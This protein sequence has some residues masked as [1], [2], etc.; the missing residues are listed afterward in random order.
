MTIAYIKSNTLRRTLIVVL[1]P[2]LPVIFAGIAFVKA[3][4]AFIEEIKAQTFGGIGG[5][6]EAL[7][8]CWRGEDVPRK[9]RYVDAMAR[10]TQTRPGETAEE[11]TLRAIS[12]QL[13]TATDPDGDEEDARGL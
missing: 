5:L 12:P 3:A 1:L 11:R 6:W 4:D 8:A 2:I 10:D 9:R 13:A 7:S